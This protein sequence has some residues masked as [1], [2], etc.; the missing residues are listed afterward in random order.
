MGRG[1]VKRFRGGLVSKAHG[2]VYHSTLGLRVIKKKRGGAHR[3]P[4]REESAHVKSAPAFNF[5]TVHVCATAHGETTA[6]PEEGHAASPAATPTR[7]ASASRRRV[8]E[9]TGI[10][11]HVGDM[12]LFGSTAAEAEAVCK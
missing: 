3:T 7:A 5:A 9:A 4:P 6:P 8:Q 11:N 10:P 1:N 2:L 12:L